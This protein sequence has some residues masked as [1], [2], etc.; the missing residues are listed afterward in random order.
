MLTT[1]GLTLAAALIARSDGSPVATSPLG[2]EPPMPPPPPGALPKPPKTAPKINVAATALV[3]DEIN[4]IR[5]FDHLRSPLLYGNL[6][7]SCRLCRTVRLD[8]LVE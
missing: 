2:V 6:E 1:A 7:S 8:T 4:A 3:N 5:T